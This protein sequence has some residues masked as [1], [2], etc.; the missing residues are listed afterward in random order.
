MWLG[1]RAGWVY[2]AALSLV[3]IEVFEMLLG[4]TAL[5]P[6]I[7]P[8]VLVVLAVIYFTRHRIRAAW[9]ARPTRRKPLS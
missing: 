1:V 6:E 7:L 9:Q 4:V 8:I 2:A 3:G 5:A